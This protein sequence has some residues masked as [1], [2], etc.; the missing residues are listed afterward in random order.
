MSGGF[1][2]KVAS[3]KERVAAFTQRNSIDGR[4]TPVPAAAPA[5]PPATAQSAEPAS[6]AQ[7]DTALSPQQ[8]RLYS[9]GYCP[10]TQQVRM[11][12]ALKG[13]D[14]EFVKF[15]MSDPAPD[16][17]KAASPDNTVPV[18]QFPDGTYT[19]S[20]AEIIEHIDA[21]FPEPPL[22]PDAVKEDVVAWVKMIRT[23][24]IPSFN[25]TL[26]G[27]N[28]VVQAEFRPKLN[29]AVS[30]IVTQL[31][32]KRTHFL[33]SDAYT[34]PDLLLSPF[35]R[36]L[37]LVEY[38]RGMKFDD[39]ELLAYVAKLE[40][41]PNVSKFAYPL[42]ELKA[43]FVK[44]IPKMKPLSLGRLQHVAINKHY[45]AAVALANELAAGTAPNAAEAA[46]ALKEKFRLIS[47][48]I[49]KHSSFEDNLIYPTFERLFA[50]G[51][52][53][54]SRA[55]GEHGHE[56]AAKMEFQVRFDALMD[57]ISSGEDCG[58]ETKTIATE[59]QKLAGDMRAHIDGE[60]KDF[61][62]YV[63]NLN[64]EENPLVV[65]IY[66]HIKDANEDI[67]P[68]VLQALTAQER[69]QYMHNFAVTL[70]P[71][72]P[73]EW[74]KLVELLPLYLTPEDLDDLKFRLPALTA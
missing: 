68:F 2:S 40:H 28:P 33:V 20:S 17:F 18:L 66:F 49:D 8:Y 71:T 43:F 29:A 47:V 32:S 45:A 63:A 61:M 25:K 64:D 50:D 5:V 35:L 13:V 19:N 1:K 42:P 53:T 51:P 31:K 55:R 38:F 59:L 62:S 30:K 9:R 46:K 57:R 60:E 54:T 69:M 67:L 74:K 48:V 26:M 11:A 15:G 12:F 58:E 3:F 23:E 41:M 36:R 34:L 52:Q 27:T 14:F 65:Q 21:T 16:W 4:R 37:T 7:V 10:F 70:K 44:A 73:D 22:S 6:V 72:N 39:P 24:L 56:G